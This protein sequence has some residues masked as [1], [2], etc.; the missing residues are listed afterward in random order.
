MSGIIKETN[1][2]LK[3]GWK[4]TNPKDGI[5]TRKAGLSN[6]PFPVLFETS[7]AFGEGAFKY[8][9]HNYRIFG[10][11]ASVYV[12]ATTRHVADWWEGEDIDSA[13]QLSHITKAIASL[14][15]LRDA[16]INDRW[17]DDRPPK[18]PR[19]WLDS[20]NAAQAAMLDR[21]ARDNDFGHKAP[22]TQVEENQLR[23]AQDHIDPKTLKAKYLGVQ[24]AVDSEIGI[25]ALERGELPP[26][27]VSKDIPFEEGKAG[28]RGGD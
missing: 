9:R 20:L 18:A 24:L 6:L 14:M 21:M 23:R 17:T 3:D 5:G 2:L 27:D 12:D 11:C 1:S 16:M 13:S 15:V 28:D 22:H 19:G 8:R 26:G 25:S 4:D 10:V 7:I